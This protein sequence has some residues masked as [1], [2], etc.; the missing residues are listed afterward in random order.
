MRAL[1]VEDDPVSAKLIETALKD[2]GIICEPVLAEVVALDEAGVHLL[3]F[4][5]LDGIGLG[6]RVRLATGHDRVRPSQPRHG[7]SPGPHAGGNYSFSLCPDI[8]GL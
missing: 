3:P 7:P 8:S 6:A 4:S 5:E 1:V 2:E